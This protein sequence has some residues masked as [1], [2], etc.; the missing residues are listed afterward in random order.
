MKFLQSNTI[1]II[2]GGLAL[3]GAL[4][5]LGFFSSGD[6]LLKLSPSNISPKIGEPFDISAN[7]INN[8]VNTVKGVRVTLKAPGG[9][10]FFDSESN[11][12]E[13][14]VGDIKSGGV[15]PESFKVVLVPKKD[16]D[17][18]DRKFMATVSYSPESVVARFEKS[19]E[20]DVKGFDS[21]IIASIK[22]PEKVF[23]GEE[24]ENTFEYDKPKDESLK[25]NLKMEYPPSFTYTSSSPSANS[26]GVWKLNNPKGK[27]VI[28]GKV[29]L[30]D[31]QIFTM[32]SNLVASILGKEYIIASSNRDVQVS[33][34]PL[35]L[36]I[37]LPD[38]SK[39]A[40][41]PGETLDYTV[42]YRNNTQVALQD[43][44]LKAQLIG[45]IYDFTFLN[46]NGGSFN[47]LNNTI[48]WNSAN[49]ADFKSLTAGAS[50]VINF[51]IKLKQDYPIKRLNDKN[52]TL[53]VNGK[54]ESPTVPY[55]ISASKTINSQ[56]LETKVGGRLSESTKV[57]FRDANAGILNNGPFPPK[58]GSTTNFTVHFILTNF[59][60]DLSGIEI[61]TKLSD[62]VSFTGKV[63]SNITSSP[64]YDEVSNT[65]TWKID[66][67][68]ATTGITGDAAEAIF[69]IAANPSQFNA[70]NYMNLIGD[71][72][73][74]AYDEFTGVT[75]TGT[76]SAVTT[77]LPDDMSVSEGSGIVVQ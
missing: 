49:I 25:I 32:K 20:L 57:Y 6:I 3:V 30:P 71:T 67:L 65:V 43:I 76:N 54:I 47:S 11:F 46:V 72:S 61:S 48:S 15:H 27:I 62:G 52:F 70:G 64:K 28:R 77:R 75:L 5:F 33:Q 58:V 34:S 53:K 39:V 31:G 59:S 8:S 1:Y 50:G 7:F 41:Y 10:V 42:S 60:T 69:Q 19:E 26:D 45:T 40:Y 16:G 74:K 68:F 66:K 13:R 14:E 18:L 51:S 24:F 73:I 17:S 35:S 38:S 21:A 44:I 4:Y 63:K 36:N 37:S 2:F 29:D 9:V 22:S 56:A 23:S 55:L 12:E